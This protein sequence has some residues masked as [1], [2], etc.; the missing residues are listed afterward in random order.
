MTYAR[1]QESHTTSVRRILH[2]IGMS[3]KTGKKIHINRADI[4]ENR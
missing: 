1:K 3:A 2:R 4:E